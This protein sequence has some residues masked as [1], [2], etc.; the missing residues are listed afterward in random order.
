MPP[1]CRCAGIRTRNGGWGCPPPD[2]TRH[3]DQLGRLRQHPDLFPTAVEELLR[4]EPP[5]H[6]VTRTLLAGVDVAGTTISKGTRLVLATASAN[7]DPK[8]F[9]DPDRFDPTRP[10]NQHLGFGSGI[11]S[12]YGA[13]LARI[14][15]HIA[16][17]ALIPHL[18]TATLAQDPPTY[19]RSAMLRGP[20][21][22]FAL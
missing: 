12:C 4:Y 2:L 15:A 9:R 17:S 11:H 22:H 19:R 3:P 5:V 13:P 10:D 14:E 16:L 6:L 20:R 1:G 8:R 21:H 7:R 18:G